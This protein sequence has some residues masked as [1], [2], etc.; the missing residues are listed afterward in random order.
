MTS[1]QVQVNETP[2]MSAQDMESLRDESGLIAGKFKTVEDMVASYKELEGKLGGVQDTQTE[3]TAE[4]TT[5]EDW[6]PNE[7]YGEGL[8][9]VLNEAGIDT[10]EI[11]N[12]FEETGDIRPDD[13]TKLEQAGFSKQIIETYLN[14]L[15]GGAAVTD[16]I[17][18]SQ[19]DDIKSV[20][21]GDEGY[22]KL[23]EWTQANVPDETLKAFDKILDTQDPTMIKVAV[24]GFAA[25]MRQAEGYEPNLINGR[26]PQGVT[27]FKTSKE[28]EAAMGDPRYGKDEAYTLSVYKRLEDSTVV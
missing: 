27:P 21:G 22:N 13:Y 1:S 24:E 14:G 16:E 11:T 19:L 10:Q 26:S 17:Q 25:Q 28:I 18:Q 12:V 7:I 23:R 5:Q 8:A 3:E 4:E 6:N 2:P 20:V 9:S 15:R